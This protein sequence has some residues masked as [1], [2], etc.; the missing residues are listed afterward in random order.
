MHPLCESD[1]CQQHASTFLLPG[2]SYSGDGDFVNAGTA[3]MARLGKHL[4]FFIRKKM[5]EDLVWQQP[6]VIFSGACQPLL[7]Q[8][9]QTGLCAS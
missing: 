5:S 2:A 4:R 7:Q 6:V 8:T 3:F 1:R 9:Q